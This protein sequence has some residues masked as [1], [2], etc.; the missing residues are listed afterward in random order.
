MTDRIPF[1]RI[2]LCECKK[3][4]TAKTKADIR[5]GCDDCREK[6]RKIDHVQE[7]HAYVAHVYKVHLPPKRGQ[8][9]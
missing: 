7:N 5:N 9:E 6:Q 8:R 4:F 1:P 3:P 2:V